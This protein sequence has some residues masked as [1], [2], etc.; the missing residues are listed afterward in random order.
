MAKKGGS[1]SK[2]DDEEAFVPYMK[3]RDVMGRIEIGSVRH[4]VLKAGSQGF[5]A[6][7]NQASKRKAKKANQEY[8]GSHS[9]KGLGIIP[10]S[11]KSFT[12][13]PIAEPPSSKLRGQN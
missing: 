9:L 12:D 7:V 3:E 6:R 13:L 4:L 10:P 2:S 8:V 1:A 11:L 5:M